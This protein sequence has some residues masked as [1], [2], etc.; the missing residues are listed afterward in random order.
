MASLGAAWHGKARRGEAREP[1]V[2]DSIDGYGTRPGE[3]G[4]GKAWRGMARQ[5]A[6]QGKTRKPSV[7]DTADG[8]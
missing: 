5:G 4:H 2:G 7:G 8:Y 1:S 3:A 6:W